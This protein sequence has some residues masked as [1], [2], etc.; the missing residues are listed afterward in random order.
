MRS[1]I[2]T[3]PG[4]TFQWLNVNYKNSIRFK[5]ISTLFT[6]TMIFLLFFSILVTP[7]KSNGLTS[8]LRVPY[9]RIPLSVLRYI[10]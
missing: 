5:L 2:K 8:R 6:I 1:G 3:P 10:Q 7:I 4:Q 9:L